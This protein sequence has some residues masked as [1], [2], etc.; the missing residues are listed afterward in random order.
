MLSKI[1]KVKKK[2]GFLI[3]IPKKNQDLRADLP[4]IGFDTVKYCKKIGLKGIILKN[5]KH[6]ILDK[7]KIIKFSNKHKMILHIL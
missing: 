7:T 1:N 3:K 6:I 2:N 4:T 5:N